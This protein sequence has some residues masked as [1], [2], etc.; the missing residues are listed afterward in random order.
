MNFTKSFISKKDNP[1][2]ELVQAPSD[3]VSDIV[4]NFDDT[5][6]AASSWDGSVTI[7]K[8]P[9]YPTTPFNLQFEKSVNLGKPVLSLCFFGNT[10]FCGLSDGTIMSYDSSVVLSGAHGAPVK[11]LKN[12]QNQFLISGSF[13]SSLKFWKMENATLTNF[14][15]ISLPSKVYQMDLQGNFLCV[16][17]SDKSVISYNLQN[18]N[19]QNLSLTKFTYS[20][21]S[22]GCHK[23]MDSFAIGGIEGKVEISS[24]ANTERRVVF[25]THRQGS[26][27]YSV[28]VVKFH[29]MNSNILITGGSDGF[30]NVFEK[31]NR[32]KY[33]TY[34]F[35]SP[36]T[37]GDFSNSGKYFAFAVGDDWSKGYTGVPTKVSIRILETRNVQG[38]SK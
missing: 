11:S 29:P 20:V 12:Y 10:I 23:D 28:N 6:L 18:I 21:R 13:D 19:D 36:I 34:E 33:A 22:I 8:I 35:G 2:V 32:S 30:I 1:S 31:V 5:L 27:I 17:L 37:A 7:Y 15:S 3:S 26:K 4:F 16:A 9:M 38:L 25:R 14:H 24:R